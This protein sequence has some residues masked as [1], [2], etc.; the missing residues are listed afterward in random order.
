M[1]T[2]L[3][4][5]LDDLARRFADDVLKAVGEASLAEVYDLVSFEEHTS[6]VRTSNREKH[7]KGKRRRKKDNRGEKGD[8]R[9]PWQSRRRKRS[10]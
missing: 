7:Q 8:K 2:R 4:E 9:R 6:N 10:G 1:R 5:L 3:R